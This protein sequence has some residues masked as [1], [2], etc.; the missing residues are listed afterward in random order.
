MRIGA[1]VHQ[2]QVPRRRAPLLVYPSDDG[3]LVEDELERL[4]H[5]VL[6]PAAAHFFVGDAKAHTKLILSLP[7]SLWLLIARLA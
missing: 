2:A 4:T 3:G 6:D 7:V 1:Q 5:A